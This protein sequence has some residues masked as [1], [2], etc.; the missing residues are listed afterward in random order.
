MALF[1]GIKDAYKK[2]EAVIIIEDCF[3]QIRET[4]LWPDRGA[5]SSPNQLANALVNSVWN[6]KPELLNGS[7]GSRP[8]KFALA[9]F[10]LVVTLERLGATHDFRP[11]TVIA[12]SMVM[13]QVSR[14]GRPDSFND[15]DKYIFGM[16]LKHL[17]R[18]DR[19]RPVF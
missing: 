14:N 19:G 18:E 7:S 16:A 5:S 13:E 17:D 11:A 8:H 9:V 1:G 2:S 12:L 3:N 15:V 10:A 4:P 6:F